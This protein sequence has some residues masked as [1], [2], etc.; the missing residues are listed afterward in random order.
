MLAIE[1]RP[2][3]TLSAPFTTESLPIAILPA[4]FA[5]ALLP[6]A[7]APSAVA[8]VFTPN[9]VDLVPAWLLKPIAILSTI[10]VCVLYWLALVPIEMLL[11]TL[12]LVPPIYW[13][14]F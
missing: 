3:A 5:S 12:L 10:S 14:A 4:P 2:N 13:P 7:T 11:P 1:E 6:M 9:E 8:L